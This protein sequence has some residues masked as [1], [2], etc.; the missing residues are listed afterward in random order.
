MYAIEHGGMLV[1]IALYE[2]NIDVFAGHCK[3]IS[4]FRRVH[5]WGAT[6]ARVKNS[7]TAPAAPVAANTRA[8][9]TLLLDA[10]AG[11]TGVRSVP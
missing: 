11:L 1:S 2:I 5:R 3:N 9:L 4:W 6:H 8:L 7:T 10:I